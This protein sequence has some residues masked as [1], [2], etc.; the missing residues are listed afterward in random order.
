M[1]ASFV[2]GGSR[3]IKTQA[4]A[5]KA[6]IPTMKI[7]LHCHSSWSDGQLSFEALLQKAFDL[8][9][10]HLAITDHDTFAGYQVFQ[11]SKRLTNQGHILALYTGL[12]ISCRWSNMDIHIVGLD[13]DIKNTM[14]N[15]AMFAQNKCREERAEK[16]A[17]KLEKQGFL[18][19]LEGARVFAKEGV[20]GRPHFAEFLVANGHVKDMKQAFDRYLAQGKSCYQASAW[21]DIAE[22]IMWIHSAGGKAVLAHP[23]RYKMTATKLRRLVA[24]FAENGGQALEFV[25]GAGNKDSQQFL[26]SLCKEHRLMAS[27]ASD[28][29]HEKQIWQQL[30]RTGEIPSLLKGVWESFGEPFARI[31]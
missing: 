22:A 29:H 4:Y 27:A 26:I 20:I 31:S 17:D 7:D 12:E 15:S 14:I 10:T 19:A 5:F 24:Y 11:N 3:K 30:G 21:P 18:N 28:F 23:T 1:T 6:K 25:G 13:F 16:I 2:S 9:L 8:E